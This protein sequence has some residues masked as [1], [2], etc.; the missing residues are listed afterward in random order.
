[1]AGRAHWPL[2]REYFGEM[3]LSVPPSSYIPPSMFREHVWV[4]QRLRDETESRELTQSL[5][6]MIR[7]W[8]IVAVIRWNKCNWTSLTQC[9]EFYQVQRRALA[10]SFVMR[11]FSVGS[12]RPTPLTAP[13][14][15]WTQSRSV[16]RAST[17]GATV[18]ICKLYSIISTL[19]GRI[20]KEINS[21]I[22]LLLGRFE[23]CFCKRSVIP[24]KKLYPCRLVNLSKWTR[25]FA[26]TQG[27]LMMN[28]AWEG[29]ACS[30]VTL[31]LH[32]MLRK[33]ID[34]RFCQNCRE[35]E[36][37]K[38]CDKSQQHIWEVL[39]EWVSEGTREA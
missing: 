4:A 29:D 7:D 18:V 19:S 2:A 35:E 22:H 16:P 30:C 12:T 37:E 32:E 33:R 8:V 39:C 21:L 5:S 24:C 15:G 25:I 26:F 27:N 1:M 9:L 13:W 3:S 10:D 20:L 36:E 6:L 28:L 11:E 17:S 34:T 23:M 14:A 31:T 38:K